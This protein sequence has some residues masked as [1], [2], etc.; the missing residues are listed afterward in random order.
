MSSPNPGPL[1]WGIIATGAISSAFAKDLILSR[2]DANA[3]HII[4][5]IGSSSLSKGLAFVSENIPHVSPAPEVY[6]GYQSVYTDPNVDIVYIGTLHSFHKQ[7]CIDAIHAGKHV[8]CEKPF[9]LNARDAQEVF[10]LAKEKGVFVM[11]AMWTRFF[12]LTISL[13]HLLH[14]EKVIGDVLRVFA[15]FS[16][17]H[18]LSEKGMDSRLKNPAL[19]AGSLLNLGVY[20]LTWAL[21]ALDGQ[22]GEVAEEL[23][24]KGVQTLDEGIDVASTVVVS[25]PSTGRQGV[26]T[27]SS[28]FKSPSKEFCR[29][30]GSKG[31]VVVEGLF[32]SRPDAFTLF[33]KDPTGNPVKRYRFDI[34]G[35]GFYWEADA[36]AVDIAAGRTQNERMPWAETIRVMGIMD[37]ARRQGGARFPGDD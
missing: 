28:C 32:A 6:E 23:E 24:I 18:K 27:S 36:V 11:E 21:L 8:L 29:I 3:Q 12:P 20:S 31:H 7:N 2:A 13:Q 15:D 10:A 35:G 19:G 17:D 14:E 16:T 5:A 25:F 1:R 26:C 9:T 30:E 4:T 22:I 37:E 33:P 34:L